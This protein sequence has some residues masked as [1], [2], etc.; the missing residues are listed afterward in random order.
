MKAS[1]AVAVRAVVH[2]PAHDLEIG[3]TDQGGLLLAHSPNRDKGTQQEAPDDHQVGRIPH[4]H[5]RDLRM[6]SKSQ[7]WRKYTVYLPEG[8]HMN[9]R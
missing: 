8:Q 4:V 1:V 3:S 2:R 9:V 5:C 7:D 6:S